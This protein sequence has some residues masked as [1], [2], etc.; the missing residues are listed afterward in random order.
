MIEFQKGKKS[1]SKNA[2]F[3]PYKNIDVDAIRVYNN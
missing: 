1:R 3:N 2:V